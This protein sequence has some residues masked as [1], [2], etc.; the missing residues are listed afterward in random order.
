MF[1]FGH[2]G[3]TLGVA[4]LINVT[5]IKSHTLHKTNRVEWQPERSSELPASQ[6]GYAG[7]IISWLSSLS[8]RIDI[9]LLFIGSLLPDIVDKPV[10]RFF[11]SDV[12]SNGRIFCHTL[13]FLIVL[14]VGG[15]YLYWNRKK[16]C[17]LV[18]AF[19]TF[20]HLIL[21]TMW[22]MPETLLWPLYGLQFKRV[23]YDN[24]I[25]HI[26]YAVLNQPIIIIPELVGVVIVIWFVWLL[27][28][29][30]SLLI[31]VKNGRI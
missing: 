21:D 7:G 20:I 22:L 14:V 6:K 13:L 4:V 18:L 5:L 26:L 30:R 12:F 19:G 27:V 23:Y 15:L 9:R 16:T 3:L 31:F 29:Q 25:Q 28:H 1:V 8:S 17:L 10:G 11:F 24:W 2:A